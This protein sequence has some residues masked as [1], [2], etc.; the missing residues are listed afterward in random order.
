MTDHR[1]GVMA[2]RLATIGLVWLLAACQVPAAAPTQPAGLPQA[3][4]PPAVPTAT[5]DSGAASTSP[6]AAPT[7]TPVTL[8]AAGDI[9]RCDSDADD[10]TATLV[11]TIPGTVLV[12]GD[13]AYE[14]GSERDFRD[15]YAPTWGR[16]LERTLAVPGNHEYQTTGA[17]AYFDYFGSR[18]GPAGRGWYALPLGAWR[19]IALDSECDLVGGCEAGSEQFAWLKA[20]LADHPADCTV[21]AFHRPRFSSGYHGDFKAIDPL[22]RLVVDGGADLVLNGHEHS[23]E[24]LGPVDADGRPAPDGTTVIIVG[25]GGAPLRGFGSPVD[26]SAVRIGDRHGVLVLE[27]ADGGYRWA[28]RSTPDGTVED[29]GS[30]VCH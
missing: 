30:G 2:R 13:S 22:W 21:V 10:E 24:R 7:G 9:G 5:P 16:L 17:A 19:L 4:E 14:D 3:T 29:E 15:C 1:L 23:Y 18:A 28:F 26:A 11:G 12:L 6:G 20:E 8:I 25:T 27:L